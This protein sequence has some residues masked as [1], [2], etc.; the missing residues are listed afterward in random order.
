[1]T[2]VAFVVAAAAGAVLRHLVATAAGEARHGIL[3][4]NVAGSFVLGLLVGSSPTTL[5]VLGTGF[6]GALTT[7]STFAYDTGARIASEAK[8]D[9]VVHAALS[10]ALGLAAAAAGLAVA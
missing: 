1:M 6:C 4:V 10:I 5:V 8:R 7:W 9:A 3:V 2:V